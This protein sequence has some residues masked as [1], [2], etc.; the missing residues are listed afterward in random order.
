MR[1]ILSV[2]LFALSACTSKPAP[3]TTLAKDLSLAGQVSVDSA[4]FANRDTAL[5]VAPVVVSTPPR[6]VTK[7]VPGPT[8]TRV[9]YRDRP[10]SRS[11]NASSTRIYS[12]PAVRTRTRV[13]KNTKRDAAIGAASGAVI[14]GVLAKGGVKGA[15]IGGVVGGVLGGV[16]GNNVDK[17]TR[18]D[19]IRP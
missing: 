8:R 18:V 4:K 7:V 1:K 9:V 13:D 6:T 17:R 12:E 2:L 11:R 14:G 3:D 10:T 19:T 15:V 16:I 5:T